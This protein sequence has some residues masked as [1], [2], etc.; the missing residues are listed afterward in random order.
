MAQSL[1]PPPRTDRTDRTDTFKR[2]LKNSQV[3]HNYTI[4][5][6]ESRELQN[7]TLI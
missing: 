4:A 5:K 2:V 3:L 1:E 6:G 7:K